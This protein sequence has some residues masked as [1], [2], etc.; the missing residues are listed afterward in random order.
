MKQLYPFL[1]LFSAFTIPSAAQDLINKGATL[2]VKPGVSLYVG[3]NGLSN[4]AGST[5]TNAGVLRVDGP[6]T[7]SAAATLD[8]STGSVEVRGGLANAGTVQAGTSTI[9][10]SGASDELLS[11]G[12]ATFYRAVVDKPTSGAN[13]LRLTGDLVVS[14]MLQLVAG[15]INTQMPSGTVYTLRLPAGATFAGEAPGRYVL[16]ALQITR[17]MGNG[18]AVDFGHGAV[19]DPA[20]NNL[21]TVSITRVAGLQTADVSYGQNFNNGSLVGIDRIWT[22][23]PAT[24]P[25]T[26]VQ[27]T[28][29][30]LPDNDN[31]LTAFTQA[32]VWQQAA[33]G[34]PW[35]TVGPVANASTRSLT[36][37]PTV[38]NRFT[39]NTSSSP[40]A[41]ALPTQG[42]SFSVYPTQVASG[43]NATYFYKGP[44]Q[45]ATLQV[46][47]MVG[48]VVRTVAVDGHGLGAVPLAGL[49]SG[50]YLLRYSTATASFSSR[51]V[52]E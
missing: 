49:A 44:A 34:Q 47:D 7:N 38:L 11:P 28:L 41:T 10:F 46:L 17:S 23:V 36:G 6:L 30:W 3:R 25:T 29:S 43:Q 13:T 35:T 5:L 8:L 50:P 37:S 39:V 22:V 12:G 51:C 19:L 40:L 18:A 15:Q 31:G 2:I 24:Q 9:T 1:L 16:G 32:Q 48:R 27:L 45:L 20:T 21:G 42:A 14:N 26:P 52:V 33:T 4:Q